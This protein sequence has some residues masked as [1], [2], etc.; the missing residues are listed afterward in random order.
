[1]YAD[2]TG[3]CSS[4]DLTIVEV[5]VH[6]SVAVLKCPL[7][8]ISA[9]KSRLLRMSWRPHHA[10]CPFR[11]LVARSMS[12]CRVPAVANMFGMVM[13]RSIVAT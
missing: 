13:N 9:A 6:F 10:A 11:R 4:T 7:V 12:V 5:L 2:P 8:C 1:M 3:F